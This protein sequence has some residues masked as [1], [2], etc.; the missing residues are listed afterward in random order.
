MRPVE[1][2]YTVEL[3]AELHAELLALLRGLAPADWTRPT[4]AAPW[5]VHDVVA[6]LLDT[7]IRRLSLR[8]DGLAPL[9]P[10]RPI[11]GYA[12]LV[13]FLDQLNAEWVRAARRISPP[14]LIQFHELV[15]P[16]L[17]E[18]LRTLDPF[19]PG[20]AVAWAGETSSANW[21]DIAREYTEQWHHQQHIREAVGAPGLTARKWLHPALDT[22]VRGLPAAYREV[23]A[24]DGTRLLLAISGAAGDTWSLRRESGGWKLYAG[25]TADADAAITLDEDTAWRVFTKGLAPDEAMARS[26]FGG[27][28]ALAAQALRLL[29]IMA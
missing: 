9:P 3:I 22:F 5:I 27:D 17:H 6:H 10:A 20:T 2:L 26:R 7:S 21:F 19:A 8:R 13:V 12:D 24:S 16:Q 28:R 11:Q 4:I 29:A 14:L 18:L 15:G 23:S 1:P 25:G